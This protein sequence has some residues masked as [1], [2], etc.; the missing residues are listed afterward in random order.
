MY[1]SSAGSSSDSRA[2]Y[3]PGGDDG[4]DNMN[5]VGDSMRNDDDNYIDNGLKDFGNTSTHD[6]STTGTT[7]TA[8]L[9]MT[10]TAASATAW[11]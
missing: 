7:Q 10:P 8:V 9:C 6:E 3:D 5:I 11:R 4:G 1:D 2:M